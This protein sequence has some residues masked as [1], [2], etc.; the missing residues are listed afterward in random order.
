MSRQG[1][2]SVL[3]FTV[4]KLKWI[5]LW[6]SPGTTGWPTKPPLNTPSISLTPDLVQPTTTPTKPKAW[7][8]G[9]QTRDLTTCRISSLSQ[10]PLFLYSSSLWWSFPVVYCLH[11]WDEW[12]FLYVSVLLIRKE[13]LLSLWNVLMP[14]YNPNYERRLVLFFSFFLIKKMWFLFGLT[15]D[16]SPQHVTQYKYKCFLYNSNFDKL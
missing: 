7:M 11:S 13:H 12:L 1:G 2:A 4:F 14:S 15:Q 9:R 10:I 16:S 8:A 5:I 3:C 6:Y